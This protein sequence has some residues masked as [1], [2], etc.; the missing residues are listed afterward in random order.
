MM[1]SW[2]ALISFG[3]GL[4]PAF[5]IFLCY[6]QL[7]TCLNAFQLVSY[8]F[9]CSYLLIFYFKN[10]YFHPCLSDYS[11]PS[12]SPLFYFSLAISHFYFFNIFP[13]FVFSC[14]ICFYHTFHVFYAEIVCYWHSSY[15]FKPNSNSVCRLFYWLCSN[16]G[17][18]QECNM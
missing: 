4:Q 14:F 10:S 5:F 3:F 16:V 11:Y 18:A 6:V 9:K 7:G 8:D 13:M 12:L 1:F 17:T 15:Q 2:E